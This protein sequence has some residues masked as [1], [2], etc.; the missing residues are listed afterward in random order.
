MKYYV[1]AVGGV[2]V[3]VLAAN[4]ITKSFLVGDTFSVQLNEEL[5]AERLALCQ[6]HKSY[7]FMLYFV[8]NF[9]KF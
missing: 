2:G 1:A 6:E 4:P 7:Y 5:F 8:L 9:Y 3:T